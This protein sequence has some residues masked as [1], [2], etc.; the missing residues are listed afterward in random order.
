MVRPEARAQLQDAV[1]KATRAQRELFDAIRRIERAVM[2][3]PS[4]N[5]NESLESAKVSFDTAANVMGP[6][7]EGKDA[8]LDVLGEENGE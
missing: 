2:E 4:L 7:Q 3:D 6:I 8:V 1:R 5:G